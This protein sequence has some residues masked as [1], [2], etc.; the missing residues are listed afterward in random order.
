MNILTIDTTSKSLNIALNLSGKAGGLFIKDC[1]LTHSEVLMNK[2][3]E[4][5]KNQNLKLID[6][7]FFGCCI[8]PGSFTG[9]RIGLTTIR[10]FA[11]IFNKPVVLVNSCELYAYNIESAGY[12]ISCVNAMQGKVYYAVYKNGAEVLKPSFIETAN[13][14]E[15]AKNYNG[16]IVSDIQIP[17]YDALEPQ[18]LNIK[19]G[20]ISEEKIKQSLAVNYNEAAPL[21]VRLSS[22]EEN[23]HSPAMD[24]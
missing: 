19:L 8:G 1:G 16:V 15:L 17:G 20:K 11:Q 22:A 7:D 24:K 10:A 5:L 3:D 21:Y 13:F 14:K 9:I 2:I 6:F 23:F 4:A 12:V 18:N